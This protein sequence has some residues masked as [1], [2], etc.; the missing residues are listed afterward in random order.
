MKSE[1]SRC[2]RWLLFT[3]LVAGLRWLLAGSAAPYRV[4]FPDEWFVGT[5]FGLFRLATNAGLSFL[6]LLVVPCTVAMR[7]EDTVKD[8]WLGLPR[9]AP[10][11]WLGFGLSLLVGIGWLSG[12][13]MDVVRNAYPIWPAAGPELDHLLLS[14]A[15]SSIVVLSTEVLYRGVALSMV[16]RGIGWKAAF[17]ILPIYVLDHVGAPWPEL[18]GS[19]I[20]GVAL[21]LLAIR[22]RSMWPGFLLHVGF[23]LAVDLGALWS[24]GRL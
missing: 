11:G 5:N 7:A 9:R 16:H 24:T 8:V 10:W 2:F 4:V 17:A 12:A 20:V 21:G 18:V 15:L 19:A 3:A 22:F 23:A 1:S 14:C 6:L 13:R